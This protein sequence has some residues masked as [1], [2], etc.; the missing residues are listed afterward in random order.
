MADYSPYQQKIIKRYYRN[1]DAIQGQRLAE[2]T[3]ELYLAETDKKRDRLWKQVGDSLTKLEFPASRIEHLLQKRD[4]SLLPGIL[5]EL[6]G[7]A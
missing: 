1:Y 6:E 7:S 4:P 2:L 3:T 5:K